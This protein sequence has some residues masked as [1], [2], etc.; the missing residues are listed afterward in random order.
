MD[1]LRVVERNTDKRTVYVLQY[2]NFFGWNDGSSWLTLKAAKD[3]QKRAM[4]PDR[5]VD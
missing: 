5:V 1:D 4:Q 2:R 3:A